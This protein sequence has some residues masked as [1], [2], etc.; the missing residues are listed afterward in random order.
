MKNAKQIMKPFVLRRLK[1]EVLRDL[2]K[3]N[4]EVMRIS[5][6]E[7]QKEMYGNLL[8]E[9]SDEANKNNIIN[10]V[11]MMMQLRKL[12]NHPLLFRSYYTEDKLKV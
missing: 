12:A 10:G 1:S 11:G 7:K 8:S 2:P 5:M 9:F 6:I 3:K 4:E